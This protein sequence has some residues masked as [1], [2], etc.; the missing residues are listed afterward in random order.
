ME[1]EIIKW[2]PGFV[3]MFIAAGLAVYLTREHRAERAEREESWQSFIEERDYK[4]QAFQNSGQAR[5]EIIM[6]HA[7]NTISEQTKQVKD[8]SES[9]GQL[10]KVIGEHD[11]EA[12]DR[13]EKLVDCLRNLD[14]KLE[15]IRGNNV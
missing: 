14:K 12:I 6:E 4:W 10:S 7:H 3:G 5:Y 1:L 2:A 9:I 8:L 15:A 13:S 11:S